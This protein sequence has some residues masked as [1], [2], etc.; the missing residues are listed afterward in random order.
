MVRVRHPATRCFRPS[1]VATL[2]PFRSPPP[3]PRTQSGVDLSN[4]KMSMNPFCEIALEV[5]CLE[6]REE[7]RLLALAA[8]ARTS[9]HA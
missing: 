2:A 3:L 9:L 6:D 1:Y 4:V 7:L 5:R 8:C